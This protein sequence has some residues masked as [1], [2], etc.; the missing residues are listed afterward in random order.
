[1]Y[2]RE[3]YIY[4]VN[5]QFINTDSPYNI[6]LYHCWRAKWYL[7]YPFFYLFTVFYFSAQHIDQGWA[8]S[9]ARDKEIHAVGG[10]CPG[11]ISFK[12]R[13]ESINKRKRGKKRKKKILFCEAC[14]TDDQ[15]AK[16]LNEDRT[17]QWLIFYLTKRNGCQWTIQTHGCNWNCEKFLK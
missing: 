3:P 8:K 17:G 16:C 4:F 6:N 13:Y 10:I 1:M 14:L 7:F 2:K 12:T 5:V 11:V 15:A 9:A